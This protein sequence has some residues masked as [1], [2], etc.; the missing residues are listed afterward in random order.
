MGWQWTCVVA[1]CLVN[2][3]MAQTQ[4]AF[5][6]EAGPELDTNANRVQSVTVPCP[7][8]AHCDAGI[9]IQD[10]CTGGNC[11]TGDTCVVDPEDPERTGLFRITGTARLQFRIGSKHVLG[12]HY[13]GGGKVFFTD[14]GRGADELVQQ[15]GLSWW[16]RFRKVNLGVSGTFYDAYQRD[17]QRDFRTGTTLLRMGMGSPDSLRLAVAV[18]LRGLQYKPFQEFD[19]YGLTTGV[20]VFR[21]FEIPGEQEEWSVGLSYWVNHRRFTGM[22]EALPQPCAGRPDDICNQPSLT[23]REDLYHSARVDIGYLGNAELTLW[24]GVEINQS[25]SYGESFH[26]HIV[27]LKYTALLGWATYMTVKG[28]LQLSQFQDPYLISRLPNETFVTIEDE[29]RSRLLVQLARDFSDQLAIQLRYG[30][31]INESV[32]QGS[33]NSFRL[34]AFLRQT[35]FVG[36]RYEYSL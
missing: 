5:S 31:Y 32:T 20:E 14:G 18:G 7:M 22:A 9:C 28:A 15:G 4:G 10:G 30:L 35:L 21:R 19:F 1:C 23:Q 6:V 12:L 29:N 8:G 16:T 3:V 27:G 17:S 26:R 11:A 2:P 13:G 24:Y 33:V 34:P 36:I 25:N